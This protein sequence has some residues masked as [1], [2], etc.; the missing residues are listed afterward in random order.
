MFSKNE[1]RKAALILHL[2]LLKID[3]AESSI[4]MPA[5]ILM[6]KILE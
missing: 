5:G 6:V 2:L 1:E 3:S 4:M